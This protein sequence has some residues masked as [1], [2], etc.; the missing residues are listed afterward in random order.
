MTR[1]APRATVVTCKPLGLERVAGLIPMIAPNARIVFVR[2][3]PRDCLLSIYMH[4][5]RAEVHPW[6]TTLNG[7]VTNWQCAQHLWTHWKSTL[8]CP[9][10]ELEYESLVEDPEAKIR[11]LIEFAGLPWDDRCLQF[12]ASTRTVATPSWDQVDKPLHAGA[13]G[14][15]KHYEKHLGPLLDA[16]G[17]SERRT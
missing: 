12:H 11:R 7:L 5:I 17:T 8:P 6:S 14:R 3:D 16:F 2:R 4:L 10:M 13:I 9:W 1:D 15:W